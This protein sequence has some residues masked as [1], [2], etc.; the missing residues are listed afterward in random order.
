MM[1][2]LC[3]LVL[4]HATLQVDVLPT[5]TKMLG[6]VSYNPGDHMPFC[7]FYPLFKPSNFDSISTFV[8][9]VAYQGLWYGAANKRDPN[10]NCACA[11]A[12]YTYSNPL[13][14]RFTNTCRIPGMPPATISGTGVVLDFK[15]NSK[16]ILKFDVSMF[17]IGHY[18][19]LHY[20]E[21][22]KMVLIGEPCKNSM[23]IISRDPK[24][25]RELV[26][27]KLD[28]ARAMGYVFEDSDI[29]WRSDK[30]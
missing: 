19:I 14:Y 28:I 12:T 20:D 11:E 26:Q 18:W 29:I 7:R 30:C 16:H 9:L 1:K 27:E 8:D 23:F 2:L 4:I 22:H 17:A 10:H 21:D 15:T 24:P 25:A 5:S 13:W 6:N 3:L